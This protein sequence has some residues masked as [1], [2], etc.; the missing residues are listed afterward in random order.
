MATSDSE[1]NAS[2]GSHAS[3]SDA[4][5]DPAHGITQPWSLDCFGDVPQGDLVNVRALSLDFRR[6]RINSVSLVLVTP[7]VMM[8]SQLKHQ[9]LLDE[10]KE[11]KAENSALSANSSTGRPKSSLS[12]EDKA[13][14]H[15]AY[16]FAFG[17]ELFFDR[18]T[19]DKPYTPGKL[20]TSHPSRYA[21]DNAQEA[22]ALAELYESISPAVRTALTT[23]SR[24][25]SFKTFVSLLSVTYPE[26]TFCA[27]SCSITGKNA[28]S[29]SSWH[30]T[31][32]ARSSNFPL[33]LLHL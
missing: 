26:L 9:D 32:Q 22:A 23:P 13:I 2:I 5:P 21:N 11:L 24:K 3:D 16:M 33:K 19:F 18:S 10:L 30:A 15:A 4:F 8:R 25:E 29:L 6:H 31:L 20:D 14:A 12:S 1:S 27:S 17:H 28:A 7:Q